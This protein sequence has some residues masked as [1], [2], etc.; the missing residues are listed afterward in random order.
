MPLSSAALASALEDLFQGEGGFPADEAEA[1]RR[2]AGAYR[3]Y[4]GQA[5]A[6]A[7]VPLH[8]PLMGAERSLAGTLAGGFTAAKAAGP[9]GVAALA[10][11]MDRAFVAFWLAPPV[12]FAIPPTGPPTMTGVV[13]AAPPG[14]LTGALSALFLAG[15]AQQAGAAQQAQA[16][17]AALDAWTRTVLVI[18]TPV[19]PPGPPL[20][21]VPL[22]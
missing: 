11:V 10:A 22:A 15:V 13:S 21:P 2:W 14:V 1:G 8:L 7:T 9:G 12:A 6:G 5:Q 18:N 16:L 4:A 19:T 17:A 20:P 3:G